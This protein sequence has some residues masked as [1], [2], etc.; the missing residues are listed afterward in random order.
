MNNMTESNPQA[1]PDKPIT[2]KTV[3]IV[4]ALTWATGV[5]FSPFIGCVVVIV[6]GFQL[7]HFAP[8]LG[9]GFYAMLF[10]PVLFAAANL[11]YHIIMF[12]VLRTRQITPVIITL[13][14][15]IPLFA[16]VAWL[17]FTT[18]MENGPYYYQELWAL[19][20]G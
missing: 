20:S 10:V 7:L 16:L 8:G 15:A 5:V 3:L 14:M 1:P 4:Y 12:F 11:V 2:T 13:N 19:F 18:P 9:G 6:I 17:V